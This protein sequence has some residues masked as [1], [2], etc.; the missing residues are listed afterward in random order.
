MLAARPN[1]PP[2]GVAA[3]R[4]H[5]LQPLLRSVLQSWPTIRVPCR[6]HLQFAVAEIKGRKP[7]LCGSLRGLRSC[8]CTALGGRHV[9]GIAQGRGKLLVLG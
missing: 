9:A 2:P 7:I 6:H 8:G 5:D 4:L 3:I 1:A